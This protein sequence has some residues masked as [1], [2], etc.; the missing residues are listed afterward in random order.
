M[1]QNSPNVS[2]IETLILKWVLK[3]V[4]GHKTVLWNVLMC[5]FQKRSS[6]LKK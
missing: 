2:S 1:Y 5:S 4:I 3:Q 6:L